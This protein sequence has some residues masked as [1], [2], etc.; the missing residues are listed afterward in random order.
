MHDN[1]RKRFQR[2]W[3]LLLELEK[4]IARGHQDK[5]R[6]AD[7]VIHRWDAIMVTKPGGSQLDYTTAGLLLKQLAKSQADELVVDK[8]YID[9]VLLYVMK[10]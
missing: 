7:R 1:Q 3:Q 4:Q 8:H 10:D 5:E 2:N 6:N 9:A